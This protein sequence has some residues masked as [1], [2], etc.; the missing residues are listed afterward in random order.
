MDQGDERGSF[1][2]DLIEYTIEIQGGPFWPA[3]SFQSK[4]VPHFSRILGMTKP[5]LIM[6]ATAG[7]G[8]ETTRLASQRG[9]QVRAFARGAASLEEMPFVSPHPGDALDPQDVAAAL[10]GVSA[11]IYALG[12]RERVAMLWEE[13]TLFSESTRLLIAAMRDASVSRLVTVTGFGAGRSKEAMSRLE[14]L[15]H[16]ALLGR[17]YADKDR[18]EALIMA[19]DLDWTIVRPVILTN[20]EMTHFYNVITD[21]S[22]WKNGLISRKSVADYLLS[23]TL[24][25]LNIQTDLVLTR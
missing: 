2:S 8:L 17:P 13:E 1:R 6:G 9:I 24:N 12:I 16:R 21:P 25:G 15:G 4:P 20:G 22:L 3:F 11:V 5:I 14:V 18:Q 23:A 10:N 7:I 19:S